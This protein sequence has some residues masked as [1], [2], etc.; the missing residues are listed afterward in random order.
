[1]TTHV[2]TFIHINITIPFYQYNI[3]TSLIINTSQNEETAK[4]FIYNSKY[5]FVNLFVLFSVTF[6]N[7]SRQLR[8]I[9]DKSVQVVIIIKSQQAHF[10]ACSLL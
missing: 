9:N 3:P 1:M 2:R 10:P 6:Q 4:I 7:Y 5:L 8:L